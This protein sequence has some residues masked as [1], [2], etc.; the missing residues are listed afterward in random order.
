MLYSRPI[1]SPPPS[2]PFGSHTNL[3]SLPFIICLVSLIA[4]L[5]ASGLGC[6]KAVNIPNPPARATAAA[7]G[8]VPTH[9]IPSSV[10]SRSVSGKKTKYLLARL[11]AIYQR[12]RES[13]TYFD[14]QYSRDLS[15]DDHGV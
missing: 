11:D 4:S 12:C 9:C 10:S 1:I 15:G 14:A 2:P 8:G 5:N 7:S 3:P 6:V 13:V